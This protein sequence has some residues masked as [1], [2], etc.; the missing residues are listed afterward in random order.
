MPT[1]WFVKSL[2]EHSLPN[3]SVSFGV[4]TASAATELSGF[5]LTVTVTSPPKPCTV[6]ESGALDSV[7]LPLTTALMAPSAACEVIVAPL[8][9]SMSSSP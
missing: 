8:T 1:N 3:P 5:S 2:S 9:A 6:L 4:S 7:P